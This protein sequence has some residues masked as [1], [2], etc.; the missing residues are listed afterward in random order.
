MFN[1]SFGYL[2]KNQASQRINR[3]TSYDFSDAINTAY[4]GASRKLGTV[5][6]PRRDVSSISLERLNPGCFNKATHVITPKGITGFN[7]IN[8]SIGVDST[9]TIADFSKKVQKYIVETF[10]IAG[11]VTRKFDYFAK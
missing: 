10:R 8:K 5:V 6:Q 3:A 1:V 7:S 11:E 2:S 9:A 4:T